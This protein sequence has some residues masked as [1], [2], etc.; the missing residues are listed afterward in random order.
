MER[1]SV[2]TLIEKMLF[3]FSFLILF[4]LNGFSQSKYEKE[5]RIKEKDVPSNALSFVDSMTF[6]F[7]VKWYREL[8]LNH[9]TIEAKTILN[10]ERHS[11]EFCENGKFQDVEIEVDPTRIPHSTYSIIKEVLTLRHKKHKIEK[12]QIQYSGE[13]D[14]VLKFMRENRINTQGITINYEIV[15][16]TKMDG[17]YLMFEYLFSEKGEYVQSKQIV[18]KRADW[19]DY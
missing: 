3:V 2:S 8:G 7:K 5:F 13:R 19:I 17:N 12:I 18:S 11:I 4:N 16:S 14:V 1:E 6:G 9:I 15:V 10:K